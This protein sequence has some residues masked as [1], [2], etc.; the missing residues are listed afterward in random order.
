M[1]LLVPVL[2]LF[3]ISGSRKI[4]DFPGL[5]A[6]KKT[7]EGKTEIK[8]VQSAYPVMNV[9]AVILNLALLVLA[10]WALADQTP[11]PPE[12]GV[13]IYAFLV[14]LTPV[15]SLA[16]IMVNRNITVKSMKRIF[17]IIL[18]G[19]IVLFCC[20]ILAVRIWIGRDIR[21]N[22]DIARKQHPGVAEDALIAYLYN[23]NNS[24]SDR[25]SIAIWTLGQIR[26]KKALPVLYAL[27]KDDPK[28]E[29]CMGK[30]NTVLCQHTIYKA[31]DAIE[32]NYWWTAHPGLNK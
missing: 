16:A 10:F 2:N 26:S 23:E 11:H 6:K 21:E 3:L 9:V 29:T 27:Y 8:N 7:A 17:T 28:G 5:K 30:H 12:P 14:I 19:F 32:H 4:L 25:S 1:L 31:I 15:L 22:I 13:F 18:I 20:F 24:A